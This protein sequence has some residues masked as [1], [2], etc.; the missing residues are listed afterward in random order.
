M[1]TSLITNMN[2]IDQQSR[3]KNYFYIATVPIVIINAN[4]LKI[5]H[6]SRTASPIPSAIGDI[7]SDEQRLKKRESEKREKCVRMV[8]AIKSN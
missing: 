5:N 3:K 1:A 6:A 2:N 8:L 4:V 7:I